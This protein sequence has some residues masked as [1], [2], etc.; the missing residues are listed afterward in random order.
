MQYYLTTVIV[1]A[2]FMTTIETFSCLQSSNL[3]CQFITLSCCYIYTLWDAMLNVPTNNHNWREENPKYLS[4]QMREFFVLHMTGANSSSLE[5]SLGS[6][7]ALTFPLSLSWVVFFSSS[8]TTLEIPLESV[9]YSCY[10]L[11]KLYMSGTGFFSVYF[12]L[13]MTCKSSRGSIRTPLSSL[14]VFFYGKQQLVGFF[15]A[16]H[17][18]LA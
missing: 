9:H 13:P 3:E 12:I 2:H 1:L 10:W 17:T 8:S 18:L 4:N 7:S 5:S 11:I 14:D 6:E 15:V 16:F